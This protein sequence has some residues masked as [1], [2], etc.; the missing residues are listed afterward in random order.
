MIVDVGSVVEDPRFRTEQLVT[1]IGNKRALLNPIEDAVGLV[2]QQLGRRLRILDAFSGS[3]VV[4][5]M[6]KSHA[7]TLIANDIEP[8]ASVLSTCYLANREPDRWARIIGAVDALNRAVDTMPSGGG[9]IERLYAPRDDDNIRA[10]ERVFYTRDNARRLDHYARLI[11]TA[12]PDLRPFLLG[13]LLAEA[14][15]HANTA[16]IFKGFYKDRRTGVGRFGGAGDDALSRIKGRVSLDAPLLSRHTCDVRIL[17]EDANQLVRHL[18][19]VDLAYFDPPY[20]QHPYGSNYF[21]L[22]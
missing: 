1:C 5:R 22:T 13:P 3:G 15:V 12:D 7:C 8:Y 18:E 14:S 19:P 21:M 9:F 11:H 2:V 17:G 10:G 16:G 20:N 6:M 4:S